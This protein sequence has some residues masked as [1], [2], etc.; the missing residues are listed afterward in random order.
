MPSLYCSNCGSKLISAAQFCSI[1]GKIVEHID[2]QENTLEP[3]QKDLHENLNNEDFVQN[4][5][6][7]PKRNLV[8]R[9]LLV[10]LGL[11]LTVGLLIIYAMRIATENSD[12]GSATSNE[13]SLT[14][15]GVLEPALNNLENRLNAAGKSIWV[16]DIFDPPN[17][18]SG[19]LESLFVSNSID[20]YD[21]KIFRFVDRASAKL[22]QENNDVPVMNTNWEGEDP[23][24]R[25]GIVLSSNSDSSECLKTAFLEFEWNVGPVS[26]YPCYNLG[27]IRDGFK[28]V[29]NSYPYY[30]ARV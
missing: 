4:P 13:T 12:I 30:W 28:C 19:Y 27:E 11:F 6:A 5:S 7:S 29:G 24:T 3:D 10:K 2:P 22:A 20:G 18:P 26:G 15:D 14:G 9:S 1:C 23:L 25:D 21:C 8:N 16:T 17:K